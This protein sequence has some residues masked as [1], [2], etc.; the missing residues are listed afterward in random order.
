MRFFNLLFWS[1]KEPILNHKTYCFEI[2]NNRF[3][4]TIYNLLIFRKIQI[5]QNFHFS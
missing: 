3:E 4:N 1:L 5:G 2:P